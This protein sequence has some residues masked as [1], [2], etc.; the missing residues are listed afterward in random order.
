MF[1]ASN[2]ISRRTCMMTWSAIIGAQSFL[3]SQQP[4]RYSWL[5]PKESWIYRAFFFLF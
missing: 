4:F 1:Q 3:K 2:A 5:F